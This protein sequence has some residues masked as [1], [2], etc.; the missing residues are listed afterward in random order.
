MLKVE[1]EVEVEVE[2][3]RGE[4]DRQTDRQRQTE[5]EEEEEEEKE[6]EQEI[7]EGDKVKSGK[8]DDMTEVPRECDA[9]SR[10]VDRYIERFH[11]RYSAV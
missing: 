3:E 5:E 2:R 11:S 4:R 10:E 6:E 1:V 7:P 8:H 9:G